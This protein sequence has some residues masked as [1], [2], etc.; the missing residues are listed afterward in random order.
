MCF[1]ARSLTA[2][3]TLCFCKG[4]QIRKRSHP[5]IRN[6]QLVAI[7]M[8]LGLN[9]MASDRQELGAT[10]GQK[11]V[12]CEPVHLPRLWVPLPCGVSPGASP[13][14]WWG[15]RPPE[16]G[17]PLLHTVGGGGHHQLQGAAVVQDLVCSIRI[18]NIGCSLGHL[19]WGAC[20][21]CAS[22][23][24]WPQGLGNMRRNCKK[25]CPHHHSFWAGKGHCQAVVPT[26]WTGRSEQ[27]QHTSDCCI[28]TLPEVCL[29]KVVWKSLNQV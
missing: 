3:S 13:G 10:L 16:Q 22:G 7:C 11:A 6:K 24:K 29:I 15:W 1:P 28:T 12:N 5:K 18:P 21:G 23:D 4:L 19:L 8:R 14:R 20:V 26:P 25:R 27:G 9:D 17:Y 2:L